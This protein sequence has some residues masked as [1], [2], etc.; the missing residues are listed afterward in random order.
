MARTPEQLIGLFSKELESLEVKFWQNVER[1]VKNK[2]LSDSDL[3]RIVAQQDFFQELVRLGYGDLA[4]EVLNEYEE[5]L[6]EWV[7]EATRR[8]VNITTGTVTDLDTLADID[9]EFILRR[10]R[11]FDSQV[12][13]AMLRP[14][15]LGTPRSELINT[16]L[17][18][19]QAQ[20]P[21]K[22]NW[23]IVAVDQSYTAYTNVTKAKVFE[24][25]PET[26]WKL[27]HPLDKN[28]RHICKEAIQRMK[29]Y[30][31]GLTVEQIEGEKLLG[32]EYTW[33]NMGGFNCRGRWVLADG[34]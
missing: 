32:K 15:V 23:F 9:M 14:L 17:P 27:L 24:D 8:G 6:S 26:K 22:T 33:E 19:I 12:R 10:G 4:R 25:E 1:L 11:L 20:V 34:D 3:M 16:V 13:S 28:T 29:N 31:E 21:F 7:R 30:P 2:T 18:E 5:T